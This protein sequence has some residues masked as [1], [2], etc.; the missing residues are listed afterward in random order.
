M[1]TSAQNIAI[2]HFMGYLCSQFAQYVYSITD[3]VYKFLLVLVYS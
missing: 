2:L 1:V 3:Y